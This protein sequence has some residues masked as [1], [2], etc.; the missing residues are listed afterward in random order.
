MQAQA[1]QGLSVLVVEDDRDTG[2]LF[3]VFLSRAGAHVQTSN[4][5]EGA[6]ALLAN[7][8]PDVVLCDLHLPEIDGY[9]LLERIRADVTLRDLP[10]I[11]ISGSHPTIERDRALL[12]GFAA[13][14][15]KPSKLR[16]LLIAIASVI[17]TPTLVTELRGAPR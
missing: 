10:V 6:L 7:W 15:P 11:A 9:G 17:A 3:T 14:L 5:A 16:D 1:L 4:S 8:R 2:E 12:A 13:H